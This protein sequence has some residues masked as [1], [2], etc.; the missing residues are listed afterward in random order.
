MSPENEP[1]SN[2]KGSSSSYQFSG[3]S[4]FFQGGIRLQAIYTLLATTMSPSKDTFEGDFL[5]PRWDRLVPW[6][7]QM[8][9]VFAMCLKPECLR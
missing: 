9:K 5:F 8:L 3:A 6:R 2:M 4:C 1:G 7:G